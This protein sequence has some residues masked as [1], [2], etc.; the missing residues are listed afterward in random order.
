LVRWLGKDIAEIIFSKFISGARLNKYGAR[1]NKYGARL[2]KYGDRLN[3]YGARLNKY[4]ARLS[5]YGAR[6]NFGKNYFYN[7]L[8]QPPY[9]GASMR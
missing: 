4:G 7:D 5:K 9:I 8:S 1:L 3:K 6:D 2:S